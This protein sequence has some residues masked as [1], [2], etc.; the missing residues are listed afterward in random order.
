[1]AATPEQLVKMCV[2]VQ[3][4]RQEVLQNNFKIIK[5]P[6][7]Q[8]EMVKVFIPSEGINLDICLNGCGGIYFDSR[9]EFNKIDEKSENIDSIIKAISEKEFAPVDTVNKRKCP[10]CGGIMCRNFSSIKKQIQVDD[11][12]MCGE[13]FLDNGELQK[14]RNEYETDQA[15]LEAVLDFVNDAIANGLPTIENL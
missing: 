7:C 10:A 5:C 3:N 11:C 1:M 6:A 9:K 13:K 2:Q 4:K 8:N 15:R 12:Y 14:I